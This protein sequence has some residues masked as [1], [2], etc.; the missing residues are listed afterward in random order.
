MCGICGTYNESGVDKEVIGLMMTSLAHRGPDGEGIYLNGH[1]ALGS[2]RL[3]IIDIP[4]GRQPI[5]NE[6]ETVWVVFNGEIYNYRSL[7]GE[8]ESKGH[9]FRTQSDTEVIVHLYEEHGERFV[10]Y[11]NG[12]FAIVLWDD[13]QQKLILT[14]DRLGQ[15]PLFYTQVGDDFFFASEIKALLATSRIKREIDLESMHYYLSLRFL[16]SPEPCCAT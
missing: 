10:H 3:S 14:R 8:L 11:L 15:K 16:P 6:G 7:R 9:Q 2:R 13:R 4:G 1:L 12:M 5:T